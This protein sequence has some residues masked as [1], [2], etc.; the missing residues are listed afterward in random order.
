MSFNGV[1]ERNI[2]RL[3][4]S[5]I[6]LSSSEDGILRPLLHMLMLEKL[7]I[8]I[9]PERLDFFDVRHPS[10]LGRS[11]HLTT[12]HDAEPAD[13]RLH[14]PTYSVAFTNLQTIFG[15]V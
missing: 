8:M 2:N 14:F 12:K 15:L 6:I 9:H 11:L 4:E 3:K 7:D 5:L 1:R 10:P 13:N